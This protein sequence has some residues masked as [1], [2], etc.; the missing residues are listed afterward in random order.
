M[1]CIEIL[2]IYFYYKCLLF[3]SG[4]E[5]LVV[6]LVAFLL[7]GTKRLPEIAK[8]LGKAMREFRKITNDIKT[9]INKL[10]KYA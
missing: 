6:L 2:F 8:G 3:I 5:I 7:F 10:L 1:T 9:E 4:S